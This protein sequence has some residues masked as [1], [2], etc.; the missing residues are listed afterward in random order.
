MA[1]LENADDNLAALQSQVLAS[2]VPLGN[3]TRFHIRDPKPRVIHAPCFPER[4]LHHA[5]M[6]HVGPVL[7][8]VLVD[9][10]F[11]CRTGKGTL[12]AVQRWRSP[13]QPR[14]ALRLGVAGVVAAVAA[15]GPEWSAAWALPVMVA[16]TWVA[17]R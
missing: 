4:I 2:T 12:A 13:A 15:V 17:V 9:D 10:T 5:L 7:E 14:R 6:A 16:H 3:M 1:F 11:A 8:R